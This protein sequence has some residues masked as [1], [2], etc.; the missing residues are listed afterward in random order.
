MSEGM[1]DKEAPSITLPAS[2][3]TEK[4]L[5][6]YK[7]KKIVLYFYPKDMTPGCTTQAC[8][9]RDYHPK[10]AE[11][12]TVVIGVSA[13][14]LASHDKF[15][16]KHELPFL[17]LADSNQELAKYFDV[18]KPKKMFGKEFMGIVRS[19]FIIDEQGVVVQEWPK[20][21]VKGHV[22]EVLSY[23]EKSHT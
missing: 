15:I 12:D 19:T 5:T 20:V 18:W 3:G 7:G 23:I 17:L 10:F 6:E 2:D 11:L 1:I 16:T 13:D 8:D 22:A 4:S 9:F 14:S 21:K